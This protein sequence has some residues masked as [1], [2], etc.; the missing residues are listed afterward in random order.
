MVLVFKVKSLHFVKVMVYKTNQIIY[1]IL[2]VLKYVY[3]KTAHKETAWHCQEKEFPII[4]RFLS[5][6]HGLQNIYNKL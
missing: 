5:Q 2:H 1:A 4:P 6:P 3:G